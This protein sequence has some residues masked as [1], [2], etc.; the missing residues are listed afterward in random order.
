MKR[1]RMVKGHTVV[2]GKYVAGSSGAVEVDDAVAERFIKLGVAKLDD[3]AVANIV[4][5]LL[6]ASSRQTENKDDFSKMK[7]DELVEKAKEIGIDTEGLT[8]D[9]LIKAIKEAKSGT[10]NKTESGTDNKTES[11]T[12]NEDKTNTDAYSDMS[13]DE[14]SEMAKELGIVTDGLSREAIIAEL[15]KQEA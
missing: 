11:G 2:N 6:D 4:T 13:D 7:K 12:D 5:E 9:E 15:K 1:I 3:S 10:D 8:K 14:L